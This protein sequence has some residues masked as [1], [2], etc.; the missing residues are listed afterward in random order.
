MRLHHT[1]LSLFALIAIATP[2]TR[3]TPTIKVGSISLLPNTPNQVVTLVVSGG[4]IVTGFK[5]DAVLGNGTA[6]GAEPKF[7]AV[8]FGSPTIWTAH[9]ATVFGGPIAGMTQDAQASVVFNSA[10]DSVAAAGILVS[11]TIDTTGFAGGTSFPLSLK[12]TEI[13]ED[14]QFIGSGGGAIPA[15]VTNGTINV[16]SVPEPSCLLLLGAAAALGMR[17]RRR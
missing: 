13:G 2:T 4:D 17:R 6:S 9:S 14:S 11:L 16:V 10:G 1:A 7:Q 8:G 3:A 5:L 12:T 15:S